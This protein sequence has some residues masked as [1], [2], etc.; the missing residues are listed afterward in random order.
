MLTDAI[1]RLI[2]CQKWR[3]A[4]N[5]L[6][7]LVLLL[8]GVR[9]YYRIDTVSVDASFGSVKIFTF[10]YNIVAIFADRPYFGTHY[11]SRVNWW[12]KDA[13]GS[14]MGAFFASL[15]INFEPPDR[16][17]Y[18]Q[19]G[20]YHFLG[21]GF[22]PTSSFTRRGKVICRTTMLALPLWFP[23]TLAAIM[24]GRSFRDR[25]RTWSRLTSGQCVKCGYDLRATPSK[26]PECGEGK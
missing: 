10:R 2:R 16:N 7:F 9:S 21:F 13:R 6:L 17:D 25:L 14:I 8:I 3:V 20:S 23:I 22:A 26:C 18:F 15:K 11:D 1:R 4:R 5:G 12:A 19:R 24:A